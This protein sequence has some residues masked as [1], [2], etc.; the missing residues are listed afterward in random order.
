MSIPIVE[1]F[2]SIEGEGARS[3]KLCTFIRTAGCNLR[4]SYCD[5]TYSYDIDQARQYEI[6]Q[7][8]EQVEKV[9]QCHTV[10]LTGG[11]PLV[12]KD[13]RDCFI[14][15]LLER[16]YDINVETNGSIDLSQISRHK[17]T[18]LMFT[19]DWKSPSSGMND[20]ML[21]TNLCIL[22]SRDVL[23]FVVGSEEDLNEM[24][25]VIESYAI[26]A[27]IYVSPVFGKIEM[28]DIVE[29]MKANK[30]DNVRL[31]VQL[32]KIIWDPNKRGV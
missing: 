27:Q 11:E 4:C 14:P 24:L 2:N 29:F 16:G 13:V 21:E 31:Q 6:K 20:K 7:L 19:M 12:H 10:T 17:H 8:V 9:A 32:H 26:A 23:K 25:R 1:I 30:L 15:W 22:Q 28:A 18:K 3:G 5:T